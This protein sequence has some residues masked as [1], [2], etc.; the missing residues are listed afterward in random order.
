MVLNVML[1]LVVQNS[2][3]WGVKAN[4]DIIQEGWGVYPT[5][6]LHCR[7]EGVSKMSKK[8]IT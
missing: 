4:D 3:S 5:I 7:G 6:I 2:I 1:N 8:I